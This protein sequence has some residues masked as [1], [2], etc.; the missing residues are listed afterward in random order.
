MPSNNENPKF[1]RLGT[2]LKK[3]RIEATLTQA[4]VAT[5]AGVHI[6]FYARLE[7][8]EVTVSYE[9]LENILKVLKISSLKI[10]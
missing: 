2:V 10:D 5:Q 1:K 7:R 3:A 6:N 8:G 4:Q 9:R